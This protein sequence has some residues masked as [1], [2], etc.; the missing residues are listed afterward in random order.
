MADYRFPDGKPNWGALINPTSKQRAFITEFFTKDYTLYG[1]G[2]GGAKSYILR[3]TLLLFLYWLW[4]VHKLRNV[5]VGLFCE[6]YPSL[7]DRH[8]SKIRFEFPPQ[9]WHSP[10]R[11]SA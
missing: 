8:I 9:L 3:W 2:A 10:R 11:H 4:D 1:G 6:D 7:L 5:Q